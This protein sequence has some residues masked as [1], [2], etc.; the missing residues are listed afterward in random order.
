MEKTAEATLP[1]PTD[2]RVVLVTAPDEA[3]A[4]TLARTLVDE[5]LAACCN[6]IPAI[7]SIYR[8]QGERC[9]EA[10]WLLVIKTTAAALSRLTER[11]T[12]LHPYEVPEVVALPIVGGAEPYLEWVA[13]SV[14]AS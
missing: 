9:E 11:I 2:A 12:A 13:Q 1:T 5:S 6:L 8:W 10:E 14:I 7:R 3:T 4:Q